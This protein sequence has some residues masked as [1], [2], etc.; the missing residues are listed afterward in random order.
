MTSSSNVKID[1]GDTIPREKFY[2]VKGKSN[3]TSKTQ[4]ENIKIPFPWLLKKRRDLR[5]FEGSTTNFEVLSVGDH[6]RGVRHAR[7]NSE[8]AGGGK[9]YKCRTQ[10]AVFTIS[11]VQMHT[12]KNTCL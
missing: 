2:M 11:S 8:L 7:G 10:F 1:L 12:C 4:G 5:R 9:K 6:A 3:W